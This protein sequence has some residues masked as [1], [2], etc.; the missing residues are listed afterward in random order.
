MSS[1]YQF[2]QEAGEAAMGI[3]FDPENSARRGTI[4][5]SMG[6]ID[7]VI[8]DYGAQVGWEN[9][10]AEFAARMADTGSRFVAVMRTGRDNIYVYAPRPLRAGRNSSDRLRDAFQLFSDTPVTFVSSETSEEGPASRYLKGLHASS[11]YGVDVG[12]FTN[13]ASTESP[14]PLKKSRKTPTPFYSKTGKEAAQRMREPLSADEWS[15]LVGEA[16]NQIFQ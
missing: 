2:L 3:I 12:D 7:G 14:K 13:I 9:P 8:R 15:E 6:G 11:D 1:A 4:V 10:E 5:H 16:V